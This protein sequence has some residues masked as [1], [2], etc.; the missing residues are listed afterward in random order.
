MIVS[1]VHYKIKSIIFYEKNFKLT[2]NNFLE[3]VEF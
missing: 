2:K 1:D 3:K